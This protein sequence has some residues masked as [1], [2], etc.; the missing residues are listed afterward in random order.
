MSLPM[1]RNTK[2]ALPIRLL[3][4][5]LMPFNWRMLS[6]DQKP[7]SLSGKVALVTGG[8]RGV[9]KGIALQLA[10]AGAK[11]YITGRTPEKSESIKESG[12][13]TLQD[14]LDEI[15]KEEG[16]AV[17]VYCDHSDPKQVED[18]FEKIASENAMTLDILVNGAFSGNTAIKNNAGKKF[19]ECDPLF[20]DDINNVGLRNVYICCVYAAR[21]M[22]R[23]HRGLIVNISSAGALQYFM[24]VP[25]GVGKTAISRMST[26][27]A[28][29]LGPVGVTVVSLWP[30]TVKTEISKQLIYSGQFTTLTGIPQ[31]IAIKMYEDGETPEFVG[32]AV[33][34]LASDSK[35]YQKNGKVLITGD[36]SKQYKFT[37]VDGKVPM[38]MRSLSGAVKFLGYPTLANYI[39]RFLNVPSIALHLSTYKF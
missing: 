31:K 39:P 10:K 9:S 7:K 28:V 16:N 33:V 14:T 29:E 30:G 27:M 4:Q 12:F 21:L 18:L 2:A 25:Y 32:R 11:V 1:L 24:N 19:Y 23:K 36:L 26:D 17:L 22:A 3:P 15:R 13:L 20:W 34:A 37:D 5:M 38:N 6:N 35:V 8:S